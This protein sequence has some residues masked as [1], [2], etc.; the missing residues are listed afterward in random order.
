MER[1]PKHKGHRPSQNACP[2]VNISNRQSDLPLSTSSAKKLVRF[3]LEHKKVDCQEVSVHFVTTRRIAKLHGEHFQDPTP[4]DCIT[5]PLDQKFLGEIFVCPRAA[6]DYNPRQPYIETS[7]Y[8][9]HGLLHLLGYDDIDKKKRALM[10]KEEKRLLA[11][12]R[13]HRCLLQKPA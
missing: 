13:K 3:F 9:I 5:F 12:A 1:R 2:R 10:R 6:L 7:L 8:I 4:T 11:L